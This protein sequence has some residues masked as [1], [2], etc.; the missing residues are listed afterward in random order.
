MNVRRLHFTG[1]KDDAWR[2]RTGEVMTISLSSSGHPIYNGC[3][4]CRSTQHNKIGHISHCYI[5]IIIR[6]CNTQTYIE[7]SLPAPVAPSGRQNVYAYQICRTILDEFHLE[8]EQSHFETRRFIFS[9]P[10]V[11]KLKSVF[12]SLYLPNIG[13]K[14]PLRT[15]SLNQFFHKCLP[16]SAL[17]HL[18]LHYPY[19]D[20]PCQEL[21]IEYLMKGNGLILSKIWIQRKREKSKR[22][23]RKM[24]V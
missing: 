10:C 15:A 20:A 12:S 24:A 16:V 13:P 14:I 23:S 22:T 18:R 8:L 2:S 7:T 5:H 6:A 17:S 4:N 19:K 3:T 1:R 9:S 21:E 11:E